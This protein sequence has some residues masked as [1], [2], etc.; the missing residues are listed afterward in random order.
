M[1]IY[2]NIVNIIAL[3]K[4]SILV[5]IC[6]TCINLQLLLYKNILKY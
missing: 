6:L 2:D 5:T 3:V 1:T 4:M